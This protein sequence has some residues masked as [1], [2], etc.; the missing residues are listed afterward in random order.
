VHNLIEQ[1]AD[2]H[3]EAIALLMGEQEL[4][5]AELNERAN[6]LAHHLA[7]MGVRPEVR[8]GVAM[9]R[10]LEVIVTLLGVLKAGGAYVPLDPEYP[11]ER[12][13]FMVKDSGMSLL[14][15][16]GKLLA[17]LGSGFGVPALLLDSLDLTAE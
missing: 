2:H 6:R 9:E 5:Y 12:L 13:S 11:V 15:T 3:P 1:N 16:E 7:R 4:S 8:V 14:L 17:K 10:S